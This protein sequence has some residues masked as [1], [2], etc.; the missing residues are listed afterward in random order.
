MLYLART[1]LSTQ[2]RALAIEDVRAR[3]KKRE[4]SRT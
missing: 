4:R 2:L 3:D 1:A